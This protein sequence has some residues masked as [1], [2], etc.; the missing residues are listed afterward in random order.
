M[1]PQRINLNKLIL[2]TT[3]MLI[4]L[5]PENISFNTMLD[6][7]IQ[8]IKADPGQLEQVIMNL[9]VNAVDAMS[10]GGRLS[11]ET[12]NTHQEMSHQPEHLQITPGHYVELKVSDTG[13][14]MDE[15]TLEQVFD[16]FFTTKDV[17]K[18][19]G[20]GL[21]TVYGIVKQ[22]SGF[23]WVDS[24]LGNGSAFTVWF[25]AVVAEELETEDSS[26]QAQKEKVSGDETILFV[27]DEEKIRT[28]AKVVLTSY[29][30]SVIEAS[31]GIEA[32]SVI[33][34]GGYPNI[35]CLV[36]DVIMPEMGGK[37]LS[38][39]LLKKYPKV[40]TLYISGYSE[41]TISHHGVLEYGTHFLE[42]P[43]STQA[44]S[45]KIREMFDED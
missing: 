3:N 12:K 21:S 26:L 28:L 19:T 43:F 25:P 38:E 16:P 27:E 41:D 2:N 44:L 45:E 15:E 36:T 10:K 34:E 42:K 13:V 23:I 1:R 4:R 11:V 31:N 39:K 9:V 7:E 29:G 6:S 17:G 37:E 20:L 24:D 22:S 8:T 35:D 14:G 5:I 33:E 30:Y 18:G 40:K 32:L